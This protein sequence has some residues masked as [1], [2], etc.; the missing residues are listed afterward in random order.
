MISDIGL[1][2]DL[3]ELQDSRVLAWLKNRQQ[4]AISGMANAADDRTSSINAGRY[5][6]V[7]DII[8]DIETAKDEFIKHRNTTL[9]DMRKAF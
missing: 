5:R 2:S 4:I 8:K 3:N 1:L 6:E 9:T 7:T